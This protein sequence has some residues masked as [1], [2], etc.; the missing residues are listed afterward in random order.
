MRRDIPTFFAILL[1]SIVILCSACVGP[2]NEK[3]VVNVGLAQITT[4]EISTYI[5][6]EEAK[7]KFGGYNS[8]NI[9]AEKL[10]VYYILS[11]DL[12]RSGNAVSWLFGVHKSTGTELLMYDRTGWKIIPWNATLP[13][14]QILL[15]Q[16]VP[17]GTLFIQNKGIIFNATSPSIT[18]RRDL[19]LKQGV[20]TL[21]INSGSSSRTLMFNATTG[22]LIAGN[23]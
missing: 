1:L 23:V 20:Y 9:S 17:P 19:I 21:T 13:S 18:E 8:N 7:Q 11:R 2:S 22:V 5:S 10:P 15:D 4:Q 12:D 6:F 3:P 14:K 16:V